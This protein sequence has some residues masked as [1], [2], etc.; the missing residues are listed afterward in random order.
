MAQV[1]I[2]EQQHA[3]LRVEAE[4]N[5]ESVEALVARMIDRYFSSKRKVVSALRPQP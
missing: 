2:D 3:K 1:E 5:K 4:K